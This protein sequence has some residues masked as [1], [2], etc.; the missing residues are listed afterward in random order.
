MLLKTQTFL[1]FSQ[2]PLRELVYL[3]CF[4]KCSYL[5]LFSCS[6]INR[7]IYNSFNCAEGGSW[8]N[9]NERTRRTSPIAF[10]VSSSSHSN[11]AELRE[12]GNWSFLANKPDRL[13]CLKFIPVETFIDF[14]HPTGFW[15]C[16][17][18]CTSNKN[19]SYLLLQSLHFASI[20]FLSLFY[21]LGKN[22]FHISSSGLD[23]SLDSLSHFQ[24]FQSSL[25][26]YRDLSPWPQFKNIIF[27]S[28]CSRCATFTTLDA[29]SN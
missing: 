15:I 18:I 26:G 5:I 8:R 4:N 20:E 7:G 2:I 9:E 14:L 23:L 10:C 12:A 19:T 25:S 22:F 29:F 21:F 17:M 3:A 11:W 1:K 16:H 6:S 13:H 24:R 27:S 28:F